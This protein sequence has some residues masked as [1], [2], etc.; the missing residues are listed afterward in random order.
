MLSSP[1]LVSGVV[2]TEAGCGGVWQFFPYPEAGDAQLTGRK[3]RQATYTRRP[4]FSNLYLFYF[5]FLYCG[6][7]R[8]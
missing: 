4:C 7:G 5:Y 1:F 6:N 8:N 2:A 3:T